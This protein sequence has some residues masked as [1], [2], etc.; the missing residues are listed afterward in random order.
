MAK[1]VISIVLWIVGVFVETITLSLIRV[2]VPQKLWL[3]ITG[4]GISLMLALTATRI[5]KSSFSY[6][7]AKVSIREKKRRFMLEHFYIYASI[8]CFVPIGFYFMLDKSI[9]EDAKK[10][11]W[12]EMAMLTFWMAYIVM[13]V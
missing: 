4:F 9:N 5:W 11:I 7:K 6:D 1:K 8:A 2:E 12:L 10:S 13:T 3:I